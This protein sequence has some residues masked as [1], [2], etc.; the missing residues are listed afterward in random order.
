MF[1]KAAGTM[2]ATLAAADINQD[3]SE[4]L[5]GTEQ[6]K[7][8]HMEP[9]WHQYKEEFG[10]RSPVDLDDESAMFTFFNNVDR[11][12]EHNS[13]DDKTYSQGINAF[14][15]M[16]FQEIQEHFHLIE[17]QRNAPQHCSATRSSPLT[18]EGNGDAP[19]SWDWRNKGGVSPVKDQGQCGSCWTFST[20]GCLE[21]AHL[22]KYGVLETYAEQ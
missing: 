22:I 10:Q 16:T 11:V 8:T 1:K 19:D 6:F 20:V 13:R 2:L 15:A 4:M 21:S 14:T 9:M 12:I 3:F 5:Q 17:N 18:A 7:A